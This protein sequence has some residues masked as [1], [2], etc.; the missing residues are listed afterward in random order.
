[1][2][3][4]LWTGKPF[5]AELIEDLN[6]IILRMLGPGSGEAAVTASE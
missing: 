2:R 3:W 1:M 5:P 4:V 6:T